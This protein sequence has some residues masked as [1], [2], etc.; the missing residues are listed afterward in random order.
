MVYVKFDTLLNLQKYDHVDKENDDDIQIL[1][2]KQKRDLKN[3]ILNN[4][5]NFKEVVMEASL[6]KNEIA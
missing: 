6:I 4:F 2:E 3:Y 5:P 1:D